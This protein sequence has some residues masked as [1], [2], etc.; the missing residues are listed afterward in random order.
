MMNFEEF[1]ALKPEEQAKIF[2]QTPF[3]E[4]GDLLLRSHHP[5]S[6]AQSLSAEELY[7]LVREVD[8]EE[9]SEILRFA[10]LP[11]LFFISDVDCWKKD[12]VNP[13]GFTDWLKALLAADENKC[14]QWLLEMDYET[15]VTGLKK[16]ANVMKPD[17]EWA[18]DELL[19]DIPYFTLDDQYYIFVKEEELESVRRVFELLYENFRGKYFSFLE[20]MMAELEDELEEQAY[21]RREIRLSERGFPDFETAH[22]LYRPMTR[23]EFEVFPLKKGSPPAGDSDAREKNPLPNYPVLWSADRLFLDE[24][25]ILFRDDPTGDRERL[26]EELAWLS[27]KVIAAEGVDFSSEEHVRQGI[28]KARSFVSIGLESMTGRDLSK[29]RAMLRERWLEII[30]RW[31]VTQLMALREEAL[32]IIREEWNAKREVFLEFLNPPYDSIFKGLLLSVPEFHDPAA[33]GDLSSL[34][35]FRTLDEILRSRQAVHQVAQMHRLLKKSSPAAWMTWKQERAKGNTGITLF[36]VLGTLFSKFVLKEKIKGEAFLRPPQ[37]VSFIEKGF[38]QKGPRRFL[39]PEWKEK[40]ERVILRPEA[41][42]S[43]REILRSAQD[44]AALMRPL[45]S[46]VFDDLEDDFSRLDPASLDPRFIS[47]VCLSFRSRHLA[48]EKSRR[49]SHV[50]PPKKEKRRR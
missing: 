35:D 16:V 27:N 23:E 32:A 45:F 14:L 28:E 29:A 46:L 21:H 18:A 2:H 40:F 30:F 9:K 26:E 43:K 49:K 13:K 11:Q 25:L 19:G 47:S 22:Q 42:E 37:L 7:L 48:G 12:R 38:E 10:S 17:R 24:V 3:K 41:E 31:G 50:R 6:L 1:E 8:L 15:V 5:L 20:G 4:R 39:K 44:D 34:R 36:S 33:K